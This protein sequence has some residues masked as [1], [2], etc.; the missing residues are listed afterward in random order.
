MDTRSANRKFVEEM[1]LRKANAD[2]HF[3][4]SQVRNNQRYSSKYKFREDHVLFQKSGEGKQGS[5][6]DSIP[7]ERSG[8]GADSVS[9]FCDFDELDTKLEPFIKRNIKLM[10]YEKPTPIQKH[11]IPLGLEGLD[12][13]CCAQTVCHFFVFHAPNFLALNMLSQIN[14]D[15]GK[16]LHFCFPLW[17]FFAGDMKAAARKMKSLAWTQ[18]HR[19]QVQVVPVKQLQAAIFH[20]TQL[21]LE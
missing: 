19:P 4:W 2:T 14:R 12:L 6:E 17:N 16:H 20:F 8:P 1:S 3:F 10:K 7:V 5:I 13:M 21:H 9:V 18:H 15:L 11:A